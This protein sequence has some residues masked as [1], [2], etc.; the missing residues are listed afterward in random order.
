MSL[1][2]QSAYHTL[3]A[4]ALEN[5]VVDDFIWNVEYL[6]K[7]IRMAVSSENTALE[8]N[9][10]LSILGHGKL[11]KAFY[12]NLLN[13]NRKPNV[14]F[15]VGA[16]FG[17]HSLLFLSH[18]VKTF[19]FEPNS[20]CHEL[21][22]KLCALNNVKANIVTKALSDKESLSELYFPTEQTWL[23]TIELDTRIGLEENHALI[24]HEVVTTSLD[25]FCS[26]NNV[27]PD[28][29]KIDTEGHELSVLKG[30]RFVL[31]NLKPIVLFECTKREERGKIYSF[32]RSHNYNVFDLPYTNDPIE[33]SVKFINNSSTD[34]I[35]L[36]VEDKLHI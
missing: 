3:Y 2:E 7:V 35:A 8:W 26:I 34:Y 6:D 14:F 24:S 22:N 27:S 32:F 29:I 21:F 15:D 17:T 19:S 33:S 28:L 16:N 18:N 12:S 23:G 30:S 4:T 36:H 1:S 31:L 13:S 20:Y 25:T 11:I 10:A 9:T 5:S